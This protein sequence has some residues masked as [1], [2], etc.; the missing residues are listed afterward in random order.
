MIT[1][2][3]LSLKKRVVDETGDK[4]KNLSSRE[5]RYVQKAYSYIYD[6]C[7]EDMTRESIADALGVTPDYAGK[8]F[9]ASSGKAIRDYVNEVRIMKARELLDKS[10]RRVIDIAMEVGFDSL[11][12]F[13]RCFYRTVGM[14]ATEYREKK[15]R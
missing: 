11:R 6:H 5:K 15:G 3:N 4:C 9:K 14:T 10:E 2:G 13:Y 1:A 8:I 7:S 12:S